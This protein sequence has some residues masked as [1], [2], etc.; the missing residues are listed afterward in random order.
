MD[1]NTRV[2][3]LLECSGGGGGGGG[4]KE[5][6]CFAADS[7]VDWRTIKYRGR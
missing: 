1:A 2:Q 7:E 3:E 4:E 6:E 5:R